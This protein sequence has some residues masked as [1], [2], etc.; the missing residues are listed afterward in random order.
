MVG[1]DDE[2][3]RIA[4]KW[5]FGLAPIKPAIASERQQ[6]VNSVFDLLRD[7]PAEADQAVLDHLSV[8]KGLYTRAYK[9][10]Q[11]DWFTVWR[12]LGRPGRRQCRSTSHGLLALRT[13]A[14]RVTSRLR[15]DNGTHSHAQAY[16]RSSPRSRSSD[17]SSS[18]ASAT[19]MCSRPANSR[20]C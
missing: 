19:S 11:W 4:Q 16:Q 12:Q 13:A 10:D 8:V 18:R 20:G 5:G 6:S 15:R 17:R 9:Q 2:A 1:E 14:K 3:V 7:P